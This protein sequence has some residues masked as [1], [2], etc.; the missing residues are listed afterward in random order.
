MALYALTGGLNPVGVL[1]GLNTELTGLLGGEVMTLGTASRVNTLSETASADAL[2]GYTYADA[3]LRAQAILANTAAQVPLFLVDEGT[4]PKYFTLFG[5]TTGSLGLGTGTVLGP[6]TTLGSGKVTLWQNPGLY[7]VSVDACAG[8]FVSALGTSGLV[9][10]K[11]L[12]FGSGADKGKIAHNACANK[13]AATGCAHF[14]EFST[15][16]TYVNTP[17]KLIGADEQFTRVKLMWTAGNMAS[18]TLN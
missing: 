14:V 13:V 16:G 3:N 1:D 12:G 2:D 8:D 17:A 15:E 9:P 18:R 10:G 5:Q 7:A 4:S 6:H 11:V